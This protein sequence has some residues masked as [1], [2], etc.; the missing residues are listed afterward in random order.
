MYDRAR[1]L[2]AEIK[3]Y[4]HAKWKALGIDLHPAPAIMPRLVVWRGR[5]YRR[6]QPV[7]ASLLA[8]M[9]EEGALPPC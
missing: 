8:E 6:G 2:D 4:M 9:R 1:M 5:K 7:S 3:A